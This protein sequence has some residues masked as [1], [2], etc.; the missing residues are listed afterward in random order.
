MTSTFGGA[1]PN[2]S[3]WAG[4]TVLS[5]TRLEPGWRYSSTWNVRRSSC[6]AARSRPAL[7]PPRPRRTRLRSGGRRGLRTARRGTPP[8]PRH[9][10]E[11]SPAA[12]PAGPAAR[13]ARVPWCGQLAEH[14]RQR[15]GRESHGEGRGQQSCGQ[16]ECSR[17]RHRARAGGA[18]SARR[19]QL[20]RRSGAALELVQAGP[21]Q[22][23][24]P[25]IEVVSLVHRRSLT[26][27]GPSGSAGS[28][29]NRCRRR[30][31][32]AR[33]WFST[34]RGEVP[35]CAATCLTLRSSP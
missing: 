4:S 33:S 17:Q 26:G 14:D 3:H 24:D 30:S 18:T 9:P 23:A 13:S 15:P 20:R 12:S 6:T 19:R 11:R 21:G 32:A 16:G 22:P 8:A 10:R 1:A 34:V 5:M 28:A 31:R 25:A 7:E 29:P 2:R 35:R 27:A